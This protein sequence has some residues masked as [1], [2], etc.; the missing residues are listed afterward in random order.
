MKKQSYLIAKLSS[1]KTQKIMPIA[2]PRIKNRL[3]LSCHTVV[4]TFIDCRL[5]KKT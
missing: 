2:N 4:R 1:R 3:P 5:D